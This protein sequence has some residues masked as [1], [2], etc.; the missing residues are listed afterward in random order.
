MQAYLAC[1][2][3]S[4]R[5]DFREAEYLAVDLEMSALK[6]ENGEILSIGYVPIRKGKASLAQARH[7][8][9]K[10]RQ[11]VGQ[12]ATIH[13]LHDRDLAVGMTPDAALKQ[14]LADQAGKVLIAHHVRLDL[15]YLNHY[16]RQLFGSDIPL[17][18]ID[19]ME[20]E[21][22]RLAR[23]NT[24]IKSHGLRLDACRQRY[25]LPRYRAHN[26]LTDAVAT[27]E[28]FLA[29]TCHIAGNNKLK[30]SKLVN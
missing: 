27:A 13:G 3:P 2:P 12:S 30:L 21:R 22:Q 25:N 11:S 15:L 20:L 8:L 6:P 16:C 7:L 28:L 17:L 23:H 4:T 18:H 10:T 19:T 14:W 24:P 9:L 29:Q 1:Q 5:Q 26:A